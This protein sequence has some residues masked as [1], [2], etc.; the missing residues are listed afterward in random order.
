MMKYLLFT[1]GCLYGVGTVAQKQVET[2][3]QAW[4]AY[5]NQ[6]RFTKRSGLWADMHL[7]MTGNFVN[8]TSVTIARAA[9]VYYITDNTRLSSGYG[10]VTA[11]NTSGPDIPE[12]RPWQQIQWFDKR[13]GYNLMQ[14]FRVEERFRRNVVANELTDDY[15]Y[16]WRFRYNMAF[17]IPL[18]GKEVKPGVPFLFLND[19]LHVSA[20]KN[21]GNN[22]FDQNRF[23]VGFGH[24]F[25]PSLNANLGY[26][27]VF[28]QLPGDAR[29][30]NIHAIRLFVFHS[31]D[32]RS[33]DQD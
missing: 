15:T 3:E 18:V 31:L 2:R 4:T 8:N 33:K 26:L 27:N 14:Y 10:Y 17:T 20:G 28:Q 13:K 30:V 1:I 25:S 5:F 9:Y 21:V 24:T 11:Y 16:S 29:F 22:Y 19:E 12:H 32:L 7:R 6:T 23:F